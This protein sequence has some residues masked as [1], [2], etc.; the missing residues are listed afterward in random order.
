M[1]LLG[2]ISKQWFDFRILAWKRVTTWLCLSKA[3]LVGVGVGMN[4]LES[5]KGIVCS[6]LAVDNGIRFMKK[7]LYLYLEMLSTDG[8]N[9]DYSPKTFNSIKNIS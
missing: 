4:T 8:E 5:S 9:I 1:H 2:Y 3:Q 6:H 7:F